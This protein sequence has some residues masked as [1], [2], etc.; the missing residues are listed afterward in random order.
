MGLCKKK[1]ITIKWSFY[2][3]M[4]YAETLGISISEDQAQ[5][6]L[7][8]VWHQQDASIGINWDVIETHIDMYLAENP[9]AYSK[10]P[11]GFEVKYYSSDVEWSL[12]GLS[13]ADEVMHRLKGYYSR[14]SLM[15][16]AEGVGVSSDGE[17]CG[18]LKPA[19]PTKDKV[20]RLKE[21]FKVKKG[22]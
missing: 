5:E 7:Y 11:F 15:E 22:G 18:N 9:E 1:I 21:L 19:Y 4:S 17:H 3:I 8:N 2:D 16:Q 6:I 13:S 12:L 14:V 10:E 20:L